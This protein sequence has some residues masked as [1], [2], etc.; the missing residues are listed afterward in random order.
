MK[1]LACFLGLMLAACNIEASEASFDRS[2]FENEWWQINTLGYKI[3]FLVRD[4]GVFEIFDPNHGNS[5]GGNWE[6]EEPGIYVVDSHLSPDVET[7]TVKKRRDCWNITG[8]SILTV[9]ACA[10]TLFDN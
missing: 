7:L 6:Y 5:I 4:D 8:Y 3:C 9:N 1:F 2:E 10:C